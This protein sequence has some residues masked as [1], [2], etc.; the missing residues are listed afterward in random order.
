M[1]IG[2]ER[3]KGLRRVS[4]SNNKWKIT[5]FTPSETDLSKYVLECV[6]TQVITGEYWEVTEE[7]FETFYKKL[8][9]KRLELSE[10]FSIEKVENPEGEELEGT[11]I[12]ILCSD[13]HG[14]PEEMLRE[15]EFV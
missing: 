14:N 11:Y 7:W 9:S 5:A 4:L 12:V 3:I 8:K 10:T 2:R 1:A 6:D 15:T 13:R